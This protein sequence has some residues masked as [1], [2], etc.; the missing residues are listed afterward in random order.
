MLG[1]E[2]SLCA[3]ASDIGHPSVT[4]PLIG[5]MEGETGRRLTLSLR[6]ISRQLSDYRSILS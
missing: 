3:G 6:M 1:V 5:W 2:L 4:F